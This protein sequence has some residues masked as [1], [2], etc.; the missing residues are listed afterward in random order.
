MLLQII[1]ISPTE[2]RKCIKRMERDAD[3]KT[4]LPAGRK[5]ADGGGVGVEFPGAK[6]VTDGVFGDG[7]GAEAGKAGRVAMAERNNRSVIFWIE[8]GHNFGHNSSN[9]NGGCH[10]QTFVSLKTPSPPSSILHLLLLLLLLLLLA[11]F[12]LRAS[13]RHESCKS[14]SFVFFSFAF[15][16]NYLFSDSQFLE[17]IKIDGYLWKLFSTSAFYFYEEKLV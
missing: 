13:S 7:S 16:F 12:V 10:V 3:A 8:I 2:I 4:V 1:S 11:S 5:N 9:G 14:F 17:K 6:G 15:V